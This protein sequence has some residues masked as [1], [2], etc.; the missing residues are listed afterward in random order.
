MANTRTQIYLH[1]IFAVS[2]RACVVRRERKEELQKY[3]TGILSGQGQKL[4]G[5]LA[6]E[7]S[8]ILPQA[9]A[10]ARVLLAP[11]RQ[12]GVRRAMG[13]HVR[14]RHAG[15]EDGVDEDRGVAGG[16]PPGTR[17]GDVEVRPVV[18]RVI[19]GDDGLFS[20]SRWF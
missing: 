9:L 18:D 17:G 14:K 2:G 11:V 5:R 20:R 19:E 6:A 12:H 8:V 10:R 4:L 7:K 1:V 15:R 16:E 13:A 3:I